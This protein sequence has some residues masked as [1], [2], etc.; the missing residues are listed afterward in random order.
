MEKIFYPLFDHIYVIN[1]KDSTDRKQHIINE[2]HRVGLQTFQ[3]IEAI[4]SKDP[5]VNQLVKS[6]RVVGL[7]RP[8]LGNW[9]SHLKIWEDIAK[10]QYKLALICED[11]IK[12]TENAFTT[13]TKLLEPKLLDS[14][15]NYEDPIL[16]GL[17]SLHN[18]KRH[19]PWNKKCR[20]EKTDVLC[21]PCYAINGAAAEELLKSCDINRPER[22]INLP[23]DTYLHIHKG[24]EFQKYV[25]I[26]QPIYDLSLSTKCKEFNST[27]IDYSEVD[28]DKARPVQPTFSVKARIKH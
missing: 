12:F 13:L 20:W 3:F 11:D 16:L 19:E 9:C 5:L 26:P 6:K 24:Q 7:N 4:G 21:N 23:S 18:P 10:N 17:G 8:Q 22:A 1:L 28:V 2:F 15:L 25:A 14:L 27:V